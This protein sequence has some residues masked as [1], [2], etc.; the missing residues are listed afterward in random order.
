MDFVINPLS[1]TAA[2]Q[3][4]GQ[5]PQF[6]PGQIVEAVVLALLKD[7]MVRLSIAE[8]I[9]DVRS[10]LPLAPGTTLRFAVKAA[11]DGGVRLTPIPGSVR[12]PNAS[13]AP[14]Q[15]VQ[16][17][18][19]SNVQAAAPAVGESGATSAIRSP[20]PHAAEPEPVLRVELSAAGARAPV[21][22]EAISAAAT[23][24]LA[25]AGLDVEG[26]QSPGPVS[27]ATLA[28]GPA[29][30]AAP[31]SRS[32]M[33]APEMQAASPD[34]SQAL[35]LAVRAAAV[36]QS[37]LAPLFANIEQLIKMPLPKEVLSAA[38][39]ML[40]TRIRADA[41]V[42][43][44]TIKSAVKR[45][46]LF[47]EQQIAAGNPPRADAPDIKHALMV[48]QHAL[49]SWI[50]TPDKGIARQDLAALDSQAAPLT[51]SGHVPSMPPPLPYRG[52][53][54]AP[55]PAVM[56]TVGEGILPREAGKQVLVQAEGAQA[57]QTL[58][59][60]ASLPDRL[61]SAR[62]EPQG[63]RWLFEV[64]LASTQG[65]SIAQF[66]IGR[67]GG[68]AGERDDVPAV[69]RARFSVDIEPIGPVHAQIALIGER[70]AVTL[71][72]ERDGVAAQL[73]ETSGGLAENMK[74]ADLE[75]SE[76]QV[77]HGSPRQPPPER[78]PS[79]RFLD[80]AS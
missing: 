31:A 33:G 60:A 74:R 21:L 27:P 65:T 75:P 12:P 28:D 9:L 69:W 1:V 76:I 22:A 78:T 61:E 34:P 72:A 45:S 39:A 30:K 54:T 53:P 14:G 24:A 50:A 37:G 10:E 80:R 29:T 71:W 32:M 59:Q 79:G 40:Q 62:N 63:Q 15:N 23:R 44:A 6:T 2:M 66:E 42:D 64:P 68:R 51:A 19:G 58:L 77:R 17:P 36:R 57:R 73:R 5:H 3:Y 13:M 18:V 8:S 52:A 11:P 49:R 7:G 4:G 38:G 25:S 70:A 20:T 43:A 56:P 41:P 35:S 47:L 48:L 46:G 55:Q 67:E 26:P 16:P